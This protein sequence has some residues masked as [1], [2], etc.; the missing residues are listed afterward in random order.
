MIKKAYELDPDWNGGALDEFFM[1][2]YASLPP[3]LG[4]DK[5]L[6]AGFYERALEKSNGVSAGPYV[7]WAEV[8]SIPE[9]NYNDFKEKLTLALTVN[10]N[11]NP[12]TRLVNILAQRKAKYYLKEARYYF[13]EA[14]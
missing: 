3:E 4:G 13:V 5:S 8:V 12:D 6:V 2:C 9:Q 11:K 10:I 14:D 7:S 1:I